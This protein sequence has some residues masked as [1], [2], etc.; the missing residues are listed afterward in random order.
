MTKHV[1]VVG[2]QFGDEG[3]GLTVDYLCH[4]IMNE[5]GTDN[6]LVVRYNSGAQAGHT[7]VTPE[8]WR[9][10]HSHIGSGWNLEIPTYLSKHFVCNPFI[11]LKEQQ[12]F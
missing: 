12:M 8:G 7:V 9:H 11:L 6:G 4:K 3:K 10:V 5:L 2:A 1:A